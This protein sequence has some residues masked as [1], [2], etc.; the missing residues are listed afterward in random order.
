MIIVEGIDG[1]GKTSVVLELKNLGMNTVFYDYDP[2][3][4]DINSKYRSIDIASAENGASDRSF[5]SEITYGSVVR[6]HS[7]LTL[8]E[9]KSLLS[10]YA[11]F[12]TIIIYLKADIET[13]LERRQNDPQDIELLQHYY[14]PLEE[15]YEYAMAIARQYIPVFEFNTAEQSIDEIL[16]TV[17]EKGVTMKES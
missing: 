11:S 15:S 4:Q 12:G 6:N 13:L 5:I 2:I 17:M 9:Y 10:F 14:V 8:D 3:T 16:R 1:T 7:R